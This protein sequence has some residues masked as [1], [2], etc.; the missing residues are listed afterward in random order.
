MSV[1]SSA[2]GSA[3][4]A[5]FG[6]WLYRSP[7]S[8][9]TWAQMNARVADASV[10]SLASSADGTNLVAGTYL[11]VGIYTSADSGN[12]W[13][14]NNLPIAGSGPAFVAAS[15][16]GATLIAAVNNGGI[17]VSQITAPPLLNITAAG[18]NV[19]LSW[20]VPSTDF[21]L[22]QNAALNTTNWTDVPI[23][24][25]LNLTNLHQEVLVGPDSGS[26]F[27]RLRH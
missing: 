26:R 12:S 3:L 17:W 8:G 18:S 27:Y 15:V 19:I 24:P 5:A 2:D 7:D 4:F 11:P 10:V 14:S 6:P 21:T 9:T 13:S 22:Q 20:L 23:A 16:D 1:A 25:T